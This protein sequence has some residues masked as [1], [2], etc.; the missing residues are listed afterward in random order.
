MSRAGLYARGMLALAAVIAIS[1]LARVL[2]NSKP[3]G[4]SGRLRYEYEPP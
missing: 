3:L 1:L 2:N 4:G